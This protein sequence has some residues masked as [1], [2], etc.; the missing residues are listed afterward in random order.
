MGRYCGSQD[1]K[2]A[3]LVNEFMNVSGNF[4]AVPKDAYGWLLGRKHSRPWWK[5]YQ[6]TLLAIDADGIT[7]Y[8]WP[9]QLTCAHVRNCFDRMMCDAKKGNPKAYVSK[10]QL[11]VKRRRKVLAYKKRKAQTQRARYVQQ[12]KKQKQK[13]Q[14]KKQ[15]NSKGKT[16]KKTT[17]V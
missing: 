14:Q 11:T 3:I 4:N 8:I 13:K 9:D 6:P 7:R 16:V 15:K 12:Q 10:E 17:P 1:H 5:V 2:E